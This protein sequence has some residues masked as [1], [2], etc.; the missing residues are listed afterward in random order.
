[1]QEHN[2]L[3]EKLTELRERELRQKA[4]WMWALS[5]REENGTKASWR[6]RLGRA[7]ARAVALLSLKR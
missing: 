6:V 7:A 1:M 5:Q 3:V 2:Y 4:Y